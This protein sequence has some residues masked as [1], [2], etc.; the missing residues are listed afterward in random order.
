MQVREQ[1]THTR[2]ELEAAT[3]ALQEQ[4]E[5]AGCQQRHGAA[6]LQLQHVES[7][8]VAGKIVRSRV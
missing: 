5:E 1:E 3:K 4:P 8:V 7:R 6:R 2:Q